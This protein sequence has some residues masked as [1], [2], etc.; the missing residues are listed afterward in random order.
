MRWAMEYGS[1]MV[2]P[3][4][5]PRKATNTS[6]GVKNEYETDANPF[7][8]MFDREEFRT[9]MHE[10]CPQMVFYDSLEDVPL[11]EHAVRTGLAR[12]AQVRNHTWFNEIRKPVGNITL[13]DFPATLLE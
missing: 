1:A 12:T 9:V 13:V 4:I 10:A 2:I 5:Y 8:Y 7:E 3:N 6:A 11:K